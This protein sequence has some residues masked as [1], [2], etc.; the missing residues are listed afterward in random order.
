MSGIDAIQQRRDLVERLLRVWAEYPEWRFGQLI[1]N[2]TRRQGS[3]PCRIC[4]CD[5]FYLSDEDL[6][7]AVEA[8]VR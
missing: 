5:P 2:A 6:A 3:S 4:G 8:L 1:A 7:A